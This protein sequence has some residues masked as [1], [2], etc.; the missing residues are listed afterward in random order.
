MKISV[1]DSPRINAIDAM[2]FIFKR[3]SI[4]QAGRR[5]FDPG[6]PLHVFNSLEVFQVVSVT[7]ITALSSP[8][9]LAEPVGGC[10]EHP[11]TKP[12][13]LPRCPDFRKS[14]FENFL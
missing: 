1:F 12:Q 6:L 8:D 7:A 10:Y 13:N 4:S 11:S 3:Q 2:Y 9:H 5:R 14:L